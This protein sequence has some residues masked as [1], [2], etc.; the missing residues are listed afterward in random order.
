MKRPVVFSLF[1]EQ[2][3]FMTAIIGIMTFLAVLA[4]GISLSIGTAVNRWNKQWDTFITVQVSNAEKIPTV[5]KIIESNQTKI[6]YTHELSN[7]EMEKLVRPWIS[8]NNEV[9]HK[10]MPTMFEIKF[11]S[12]SDIPSFSDKVAQHARVMTHI[13][14]LNPSISAGWK[15]VTISTIVLLLI[16]GAIG[17]CISFIARN[18][19][20]LHKR[21][22]E[23]LNQVGASDSFVAHQMQIIVTKICIMACGTGF[24]AALPVL[25]AI[26]A[27]A[28]TTRIGLMAMM[29]MGTSGWI[30]TFLL[31]VAILIFA[32]FVTK[33]T[34]LKILKNN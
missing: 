24:I 10:Y 21:E 34:T 18:I 16:L 33:H 19:A 11:K 14:A 5:K 9:L 22:L 27:T 1:R 13:Q 17:V 26:F 7:D 2:S 29:G 30:I 12:K 15:M 28:H 23:I 6:A 20:I 3:V 32:I 4:L 31:P 8:G 25:L